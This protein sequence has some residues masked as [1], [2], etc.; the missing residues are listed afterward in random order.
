MEPPMIASACPLRTWVV[1]Y[2]A[3]DS[4]ASHLRLLVAKCVPRDL[5]RPFYNN[6][7][8]D[9]LQLH[10]R[11]R[12]NIQSPCRFDI[13]FNTNAVRTLTG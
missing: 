13:F 10:F 2:V 6:T 7:P 12:P 3:F 8:P 11:G 4:P 9:P 1:V 5:F